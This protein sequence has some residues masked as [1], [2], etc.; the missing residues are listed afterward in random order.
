MIYHLIF[1]LILFP[2]FISKIF[3]ESNENDIFA[4]DLKLAD[5]T[6]V[7]QKNKRNDRTKCR[8]VSILSALSKVFEK[9]FVTKF[10]LQ[11]VFCQISNRLPKR[12]QFTNSLIVKEKSF[13]E[14]EKCDAL[15]IDLSRRLTLYHMTCYQSNWKRL[16]F[17]R[18]LS[19]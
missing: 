9:F 13:D 19:N 15:F 2:F 8:P 18:V 17:V 5:V 10:R 11:I 1:M 14:G 12:L 4:D 3:N 16:D 7:Y 6:P